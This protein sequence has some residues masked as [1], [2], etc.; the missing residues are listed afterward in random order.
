M[1]F[2]IDLGEVIRVILPRFILFKNK[3][4]IEIVNKILNV[5]ICFKIRILLVIF[6]RIII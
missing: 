5:I 3:N 6:S 1:V 2:F 4:G